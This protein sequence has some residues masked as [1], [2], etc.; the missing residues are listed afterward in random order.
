L[1]LFIKDLLSIL[2]ARLHTNVVES[3]CVS[4]DNASVAKTTSGM[5]PTVFWKKLLNLYVSIIQSVR[6]HC[7]V[8]MA[9]VNVHR[10]TTGMEMY[11]YLKRNL[12]E[13]VQIQKNVEANLC[14]MVVYVNVL[15]IYFGMEAHKSSMETFV[16]P[17]SHAQI[18]WNVEI[19]YVSVQNRSTGTTPN[20]PQVR[21]LFVYF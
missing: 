17:L 2:H 14:A 7:F 10:C 5:A 8:Y 1:F 19:R 9:P 11:V 4:M 6:Q 12:M 21:L 3:W 16:V 13:R 20:V 18:I 15:L